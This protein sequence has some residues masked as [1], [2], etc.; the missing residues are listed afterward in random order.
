[1]LSGPSVPATVNGNEWVN[2][3]EREEL[4]EVEQGPLTRFPRSGKW[5]PMKRMTRWSRWMSER[6]ARAGSAREW[7]S[8]LVFLFKTQAR[9]INTDSSGD[10]IASLGLRYRVKKQP[11]FPTSNR[12]DNRRRLGGWG[13]LS[14]V[15]VY[16]IGPTVCHNYQTPDRAK[17]LCSL[18]IFD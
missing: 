2:Q 16:W 1:M 4:L 17:M 18:S 12:Q 8:S 7:D 6:W 13:T 11:I 15:F 3:D 5:K 9:W 14:M 10:A